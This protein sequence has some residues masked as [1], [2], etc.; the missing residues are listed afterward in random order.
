MIYLLQHQSYVDVC[1]VVFI[2]MCVSINIKLGSSQP[3]VVCFSIDK[4]S[5]S[6]VR[7]RARTKPYASF[8]N[9]LHARDAQPRAHAVTHTQHCGNMQTV[10]VLLTP[11]CS[12][13]SLQALFGS[14]LLKMTHD[15]FFIVQGEI[16]TLSNTF[17]HV[18]FLLDDSGQMMMLCRSQCLR[19]VKIKLD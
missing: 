17:S 14:L 16:Y 6:E 8:P 18:H 3:V 12:R 2:E 13:P 7:H 1:A 19:F 10:L 5:A 11:M 4:N 15:S 9:R